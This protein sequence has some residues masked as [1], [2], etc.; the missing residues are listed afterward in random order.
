MGL[1]NTIYGR[2]K[3]D[4]AYIPI[5]TSISVNF[6]I[7]TRGGGIFCRRGDG[8]DV[9]ATS[10]P[11]NTDYSTAPAKSYNIGFN[12]SAIFTGDMSL[13]F[14]RGLQDVYSI[15]FG[16][17]HDGSPPSAEQKSKFNIDIKTFFS[18]FPNLYSVWFD[19]YAYQSPSRMA[20]YKGDFSQF[21]DSVERILFY[22]FEA[23]RASID[24]VINLSN[25][26]P[27]S[28]LKYF[29]FSG[30]GYGYVSTTNIFLTGDLSKLPPLCNYFYVVRCGSGS[31]ISYTA[32]KVWPS[33]FDTLGLPIALSNIQNNNLLI[34]MAN[35]ITTAIGNKSIS[36]KGNRTILSDSAVTYLQG[37]GFTVTINRI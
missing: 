10:V 13:R 3:G 14:T 24:S 1:K 16:V 33:S 20:T 23:Y 4:L 17:F 32:G 15:S 2:K 18:Q 9:F 25:Y 6:M 35:S 28:R 5:S 11:I 34:D 22:A 8:T 30:G 31:A 27:T 21:P 29:N 7:S 37:L 19:D 36:L 12:Y 26:R